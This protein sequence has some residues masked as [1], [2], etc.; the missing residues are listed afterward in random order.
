MSTRETASWSKTACA[1]RIGTT[2][3]A[4]ERPDRGS[5]ACEDADDAVRRS[6]ARALDGELGA[7]R[8]A[9]LGRRAGA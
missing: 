5:V 2:T 9:V 7:D 4:P 6:V 1:V 3:V 8:E